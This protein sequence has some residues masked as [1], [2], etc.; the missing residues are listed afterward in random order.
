[1]YN[2]ITAATT[3]TLT[4]NDNYTYTPGVDNNTIYG[5]S[6]G[7]KINKTITIDGNGHTISGANLQRGFWVTN[8]G[9]LTLKN[10][11]IKDC[12]NTTQTG[13][14]IYSEGTLTM[15]N[16][17]F[18]ENTG[19]SGGAI[20]SIG[21]SLT[22][23][24][25][26]FKS[27]HATGNVNGTTGGAIY[28]RGILKITDSVF[29]N[30]YGVNSYSSGIHGSAIYHHTGSL[31]EINNTVF[32]GNNASSTGGAIYTGSQA[33]N[34]SNVTFTDNAAGFGGAV[35][36][37]RACK[38]INI[39]NSTFTNNAASSLGGG[40]YILAPQAGTADAEI[41]I[42]GTGFYRNKAGNQGGAI[43]LMKGELSIID[44]EFIANHASSAPG[45]TGG[46]WSGGAI[47]IDRE[48][49]LTINNGTF[50]N[51][52]ASNTG[53]AV[54]I[55]ET[56]IVNI[57]N[58]QFENNIL[59][60]SVATPNT[61]GGAIYIDAWST[62]QINNTI[63]TNNI[64]SHGGAIYLGE[65]G[66]ASIN[67]S[68][69]S[70]NCAS[71]GFGGAIFTGA[72]SSLSV[73]N[74]AFNNNTAKNGN[75]GTIAAGD[76]V[77]LNINGSSFTNTSTDNLA[78][79]AIYLG[80]NQ[81]QLI[82]T[83]SIFN[84]TSSK[85]YGGA[86]YIGNNA[87]ATTITNVR[88]INTQ[89]STGG[90]ICID[91]TN[92]RA[93]L[94]NTT[95][96]DST[97]GAYGGAIHTL[98][99]LTL[100]VNTEDE[101]FTNIKAGIS[102]GAIYSA[103]QTD[104][105]II[106]T[107]DLIFRDY[108]VSAYGGA[109]F[110]NANLIFDM[111]ENKVSFIN[112]TAAWGG[113]IW[114]DGKD[115]SNPA[116]S[117]SNMVFTDNTASSE[118]GGA[119]YSLNGVVLTLNNIQFT[120]NQASIGFGG[121]IYTTSPLIS[122]NTN[123]TNNQAG[124]AGGAIYTKG[125]LNINNNTFNDNTAAAGGAIYQFEGASAS[126]SNSNFT[127]NQA[128]NTSDGDGGAVYL[129]TST[130][131][132]IV[133]LTQLKFNNN[134]AGRYG[135]SI[136]LEGQDT[137]TNIEIS[138]S[139]AGDSGGAIFNNDGT[140]EINNITSTNTAA[141]K[142]QG[143]AIYSK[144]ALI[145]RN[146]V[147][148]DSH[149]INSGGVI[150][151]E[152]GEELTIT[153]TNMTDNKADMYGGAIYTNKNSKVEISKSNFIRNTAK[154]GGAATI[155][156]GSTI[157]IA[158]TLFQFNTA[159]DQTGNLPGGGALVISGAGTTNISSTSFFNN[160]AINRAGAMYVGVNNILTIKDSIFE[161]NSANGYGSTNGSAG[162]MAVD[163]DARVTIESTSFKYNTARNKAGAI[164]IFIAGNV[165]LN[166]VEFD[167]NS[168]TGYPG[169][170]GYGGGVFIEPNATLTSTNTDTLFNNNSADYGGA[171]VNAGFE[172]K[173]GTI[174]FTGN[175]ASIEGPDIYIMSGGVDK[176][177]VDVI[178][179]TTQGYAND[180]VELIANIT[181]NGNPIS[182]DGKVVFWINGLNLIKVDVINGTALAR[183]NTKTKLPGIYSIKAEFGES[184]YYNN[185]NST[186]EVTLLGDINLKVSSTYIVNSKHTSV[187]T[188]TL[189]VNGKAANGVNVNVKVNGVTYNIGTMS[190]GVGSK[191][192][193]DLTAEKYAYTAWT[194][195]TPGKTVKGTI[196]GI[197]NVYIK[198]VAR[199]GNYYTITIRNAGS[200][201]TGKATRVKLYYTYKGRTY[202]KT[203]YV[204]ALRKG[205]EVKVKIYLKRT[206]KNKRVYKY[207]HV[208]YNKIFK[209]ST[210]ADNKRRLSK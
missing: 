2:N 163:N 204:K 177:D 142:K 92:N 33:L 84:N 10:L 158:N 148:T 143:G 207:V 11:I 30:N 22:I 175:S 199:K 69:L 198:K 123:Y 101:P 26:I 102:G 85:D 51:N 39:L 44:S 147:F 7:I 47:F 63:F 164:Y 176:K 149:A 193:Y 81:G 68:N 166:A 75:G 134:T 91:T 98:A 117:L 118:D 56:S 170:D 129:D 116:T 183:W 93:T 89:S 48:S 45:Y 96:T 203:A 23:K 178:I 189:F 197:A 29:E 73:N 126:I 41:L 202:T 137:L 180:V 3:G 40:I 206:S 156:E 187:V 135:G 162:A 109:I 130:A 172:I 79:G 171:I 32:T 165:S 154:N 53:A 95:F 1:M 139:T 16:V 133:T 99:P 83:N 150:F 70:D 20:F 153:D 128:T 82:L 121:A 169:D 94:T 12:L 151:L 25:S 108:N 185:K 145:I 131:T 191:K 52:S 210:Y 6:Q 46:I 49:S 192:I 24:D 140:L 184:S 97:A 50:I 159:T 34:L 110:S 59:S 196:Y 100:N 88:F 55:G 38:V 65:R 15:E 58:S 200:A 57:E 160:T 146:S 74:V 122:T 14:G 60:P 144:S 78:G 119:I 76:G 19:L 168:V 136:Y 107:H 27:N 124:T 104:L 111:G 179:I 35:Y 112:N 188:V 8:N 174:S 194:D 113:A 21:P 106:S 61:Q 182:S 155:S 208:N 43:V 5:A 66:T 114:L 54:S 201:R 173:D 141:N 72:S 125:T 71:A 120:N 190:N 42:N 152:E 64:G 87:K 28:S 105:T 115:M 13:G 161:N 31:T 77:T 205:Q 195:S 157:R 90:A 138:D 37:A 127:N 18:E 36:I 9:V 103:S 209:E 132:S 186:G 17:T 86:I 67:N 181:S 4:L 167:S 62:T 80:A